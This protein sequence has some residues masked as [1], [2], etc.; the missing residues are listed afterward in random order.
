MPKY[1][2]ILPVQHSAANMFA[3]VA[4]VENYPDFLPLCQALVIRGRKQ[5]EGKEV[6]IADM[7]IAYKIVRETFT[8]KVTLCPSDMSIQV[9]Y[10]DGPFKRLDNRWF[11]KEAGI[12]SCEV[13]FEIDYEFK[14]KTLGIVMGAVFDRAFRQF[15]RSFEERADQLYG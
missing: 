5:L 13:H 15:S 3:L 8:S 2:S 1:S 4:D 10:L 7:T 14:S 6:L 11:F 12:S 9:E